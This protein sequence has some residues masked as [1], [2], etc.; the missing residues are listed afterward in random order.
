MTGGQRD[1]YSLTRAEFLM[2]GVA[3][4][5]APGLVG[6]SAARAEIP[7]ILPTLEVAPGIWIHNGVH[8]LANPSNG[9]DIANIGF[10]A[11]KDSVAVIDTG[12]CAKIG[13]ALLA[14][15][16]KLAGKPVSHV[17][18]THMHPDHVL[19]NAAFRGSKPAFTGH[20]KLLRS[21][22]TRSEIYLEAAKENLG[23]ET[24]A[25]TEV[26]LPTLSIKTETEIDLGDRKL[27]LTPRPTAHTSNDL[28]I[29]DVQTGTVFMGDLIFSGHVPTIDGSLLG[30][31]S[32]LE[33]L[34]AEPAERIVPGHGPA[35]MPWPAA[36][37]DI[38]RYLNVL[39]DDIRALIAKGDTMTTAMETA[40]QSERTKW[41][42]FDEHHK[43]NVSAAFAELEW[44]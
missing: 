43:R 34:K 1:D 19:G 12:G 15:V 5:V 37:E 27:V 23:A 10:V 29:R 38:G 24:F 26:V 9:G 13:Q 21:L 7:D 11:G 41:K 28:T 33:T 22:A 2:G 32:L 8:G 31:L 20:H 39:A 14:S 30:W 18:S 17:I 42:V 40:G 6:T 4:L 3:V 16:N 44:E 25:G 36:A 35:S